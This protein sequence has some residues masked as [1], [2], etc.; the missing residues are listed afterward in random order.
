MK[1]YGLTYE[2]LSMASVERVEATLVTATRLV[3]WV[4]P[5]LP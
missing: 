2:Q 1:A 4:A 3:E 5:V